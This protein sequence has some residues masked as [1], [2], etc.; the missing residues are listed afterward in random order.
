M[1][2]TR[3]RKTIKNQPNKHWTLGKYN[4]HRRLHHIPNRIRNEW[5]NKRT[6]S[7]VSNNKQNNWSTIPNKS[8]K[9]SK[10]TA[11]IWKIR[12]WNNK[13]TMSI[14]PRSQPISLPKYQRGKLPTNQSILQLPCPELPIQQIDWNREI[15]KN[16]RSNTTGAW[17]PKTNNNKEIL[18]NYYS[19]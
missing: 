8:N 17:K 3:K 19:I 5:R 4:E 7:T 16:T 18:I 6:T 14:P 15:H 1:V 13:S 9:Q 12:T 2:K 10:P 11:T